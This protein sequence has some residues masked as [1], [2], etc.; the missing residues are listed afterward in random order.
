M[1][2]FLGG[3]E[4][5][6]WAVEYLRRQGWAVR[7]YGVPGLPCQEPASYLPCVILPAPSFIEGKIPGCGNLSLS[8]LLSRMDGQ[9]RIY[10]MKG[11]DLVK[12]AETLG[13]RIRDLYDTE[14]Y[15]TYN[16]VATAEGAIGLAVTRS[17]LCL[18]ASSCLVIGAGRIGTILSQRL[19]ALG[20]KVTLCARKDSQIA[21]GEAM[22]LNCDRTGV[23]EK[24]LEQYDFVFNT[25]P[26][27]VLSEK[28]VEHCRQGC[29]RIDLAS[30]QGIEGSHKIWARGL[31]GKD[32]PESSGA[33]IAKTVIRLLERKEQP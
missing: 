8:A 30:V 20:A 25:V 31:P 19:K 3:D 27:P 9:S 23:Y 4:R 18:F 29:L 16:A 12:Q 32:A 21:L 24:G 6:R 10:C 17:P 2:W 28:Q 5:S 14:P 7:C 33:L 1:Y 22:G 26:A 11:G 13:I 15:T